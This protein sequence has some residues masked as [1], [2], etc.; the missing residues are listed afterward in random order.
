MV[1]SILLN[2]K[3]VLDMIEI[4]L[5]LVIGYMIGLVQKGVH[6]N[7]NSKTSPIIPDE[8][9]PQN[10]A[11]VSNVPEHMLNYARQNNGLKWD[12]F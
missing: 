3:G 2:A 6:I 12:K 8:E 9:V 1:L 7:I 11:N 10:K 5:A 4:L